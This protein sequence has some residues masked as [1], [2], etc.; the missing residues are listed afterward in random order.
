MPDPAALATEFRESLYD[1]D[2]GAAR[3][4]VAAYQDAYKVLEA[5]VASWTRLRD[6][7]RQQ[8]VSW[9]AAANY[10][11]LRSLPGRLF[12][13]SDEEIDAFIAGFGSDWASKLAADLAA[14]E[15]QTKRWADDAL[16]M[17]AALERY[18]QVAEG[19][20]RDAQG[21]AIGLGTNDM[22][23]L[24]EADMPESLGYSFARP[25]DRALRAMV[26]FTQNGAPLSDLFARLAPEMMGAVRQTLLNGIALGT[27][28][29]ALAYQLRGPLGIPL[30]RSLTIARTET[31][32]AYREAQ[33][34][35]IA[36]N[37]DVLEG[38]VWRSAR[39]RRTCEVCWAQDGKVFPLD[40]TAA[41]R[42]RA[43]EAA[44][45]P[46]QVLA[47]YIDQSASRFDG[48]ISEADY[49]ARASAHRD[50]KEMAEALEEDY[51]DPQDLGFRFTKFALSEDRVFI[52]G[53]EGQGIAGALGFYAEPD[54]DEEVHVNYP[55]S[56]G[57]AEG[58]GSALTREMIR[59]AARLGRGIALEPVD[60]GAEAFWTKMGMTVD[61]WGY[62]TDVWGMTAERVRTVAG[63]FK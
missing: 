23:R 14:A 36:S 10:D 11:K 43:T 56:T 31:L 25:D 55:G 1:L 63:L 20:T 57:I 39:D 30:W 34:A 13:A 21:H 2:T 42:E 48:E 26:G 35:T 3:Q 37:A 32:R 54:T 4:M 17:R 19:I 60:A 46:D 47:E 8:L 40:A 7:L 50:L 44:K 41:L 28:P 15:F 62:D 27:N 12:N 49:N 52:A 24:I 38:W 18:T 51:A 45:N 58:T 22:G 61:P 59:E 9:R 6:D 29:G 5:R 53:Q 16:A 33:R